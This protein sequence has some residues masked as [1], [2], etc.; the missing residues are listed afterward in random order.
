MKQ[1]D[2]FYS[3]SRHIDGCESW[4]KECKK[5]LHVLNA[6]RDNNKCR[7]WRLKNKD[8]IYGQLVR[9]MHDLKSNGCA[10]CGY[11]KCDA[12]LDFHHANPD[13]KECNVNLATISRS[14][15]KVVAELN[16]C[17]LLCSNCHKELHD[18][19]KKNSSNRVSRTI[20]ASPIL[21]YKE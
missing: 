9:I 20:G 10:I 4:C 5:K 3:D 8:R 6:T 19:E 11:D 21:S 15:A 13:D 2:D 17:I 18:N 12:C 14:D 1:L 16:K 7:E